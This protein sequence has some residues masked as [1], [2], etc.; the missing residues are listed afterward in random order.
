MD[1]EE[2]IEGVRRLQPGETGSWPAATCKRTIP[3]VDPRALL[4]ALEAFERPILDVEVY[5]K[6]NQ[7]GYVA[8]V[9]SLN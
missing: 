6:P 2:I 9:R 3:F 4:K 1:V 7:Q 5:R 8:H